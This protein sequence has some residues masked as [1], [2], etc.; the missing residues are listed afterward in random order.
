MILN[1]YINESS[2]NTINK[3]LSNVLTFSNVR[4]KNDFDVTN[5]YFILSG[6]N[7]INNYNYVHLPEL[8]RYYFV[9]SVESVR[10]GLYK[11]NCSVDLLETYKSDILNS[12]CEYMRK[13][14]AGDYVDQNIDLSVKTINTK[15]ASGITFPDVKE[16]VMITIGD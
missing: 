10:H 2:D 3:T 5:P 8:N 4:L 1:L 6:D 7:I 9:D 15:Y 12:N 14:K 11:L 13:L 16:V